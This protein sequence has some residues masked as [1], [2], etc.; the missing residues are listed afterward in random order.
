MIDEMTYLFANEVR[1]WIMQKCFKYRH[2]CIFILAQYVETDFTSF[3][4]WP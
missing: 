2:E 4:K 3:T 1:C